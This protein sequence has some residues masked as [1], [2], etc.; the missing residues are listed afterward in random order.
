MA[1]GY[2]AARALLAFWELDGLPPELRLSRA[3]ALGYGLD[4]GSL[5]LLFIAGL[6]AY[7]RLR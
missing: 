6:I 3:L 5:A 4:L 2:G 1:L 7:T